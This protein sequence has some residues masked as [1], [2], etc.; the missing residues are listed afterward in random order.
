M[1][2]RGFAV[3]NLA[4]LVRPACRLQQWSTRVPRPSLE[5][6]GLR[7]I[8]STVRGESGREYIIKEVL[9][10][11]W[12]NKPE[13]NI[14]RAECQGESYVAKGVSPSILNLSQELRKEFPDSHRLRMHVDHNEKEHV[15]VY[16]YYKHT[17]LALLT[18]YPD[19]Q[20]EEI[21]KILRCTAEAVKELHD[22]DWIH[23]DVKPDNILIGW[24]HDGRGQPRVEKVALGDFDLA[25]K[26]VDEQPLRGPHAVGNVMWRSPEGQSGKGVAKASEIYSLG[27]VCI[28]GLGGGSML[29]LDDETIQQLRD[30]G[31]P[32]R[33]EIVVRHFM[34]FGPLPDGL[35][36]HVDDDD[37][38]RLFRLASELAETGAAE[39]PACR[40]EQW[41]VDNAPHLTPAAKDMIKNMMRLDPAQRVSIDRVLEHP[42]W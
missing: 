1:R 30:E 12:P 10:R 2:V 24:A 15:L 37:W 17:F 40:F 4:S 28:Y 36:E 38:T 42:W 35:L 3:H 31:I 34:Y 14:Y 39:G 29:I 23:I 27:L 9:R 16:K 22:K 8:S 7:K 41:S 18:Q 13:Y 33:L 25:L 11:K 19:F 21:K 5:Q 6:T 32:S 26:L 20:P